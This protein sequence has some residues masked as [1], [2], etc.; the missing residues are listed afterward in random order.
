M[1]VVWAVLINA[2]VYGSGFFVAWTWRGR[3]ATERYNLLKAL[4]HNYRDHEGKRYLGKGYELGFQDGYTI[5]E[6]EEA[7]E[8]LTEAELATDRDLLALSIQTW[9]DNEDSTLKIYPFLGRPWGRD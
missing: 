1:K 4:Y 3:I 6:K 7:E 9:K 2:A 8:E 5:L